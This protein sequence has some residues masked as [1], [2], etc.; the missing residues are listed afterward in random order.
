MKCDVEN[1]NRRTSTICQKET[2]MLSSSKSRRSG[3]STRCA[4]CDGKFG[5][6]R[7]YSWR[8]PLCSK[9]CVDRFRE[10]R[11]SDRNWLP[12]LQIA[13][14]VTKPG[15]TA[16][17]FQISQQG[18]EYLGTAQTLLCAA[19]TMS[20]RAIAGQLEALADDYYQRAQHASCVDAA[21]A[22]ARSAAGVER[23]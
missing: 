18:K 16:M 14:G 20:D 4:V 2:A 10:R 9:K 15:E 5:L 8:T 22:F 11:A 7:H 23:G 13:L 17:T 19:R 3:R 6:V 21:K 1:D 12:W